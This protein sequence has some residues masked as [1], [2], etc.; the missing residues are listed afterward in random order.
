[1]SIDP[2]IIDELVGGAGGEA[3]AGSAL[4]HVLLVFGRMLT[5]AQQ[6][7]TGEA[8]VEDIEDVLSLIIR[9][10]ELRQVDI[11]VPPPRCAIRGNKIWCANLIA[12]PFL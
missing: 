12:I 5:S 8:R 6:D 10:Y 7:E 3:L 2:R 4:Q 11:R 9:V 1:V